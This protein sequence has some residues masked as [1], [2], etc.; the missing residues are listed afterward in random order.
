[1]QIFAPTA[2]GGTS[3]SIFVRNFDNLLI[4]LTVQDGGI[5]A[6]CGPASDSTGCAFFGDPFYSHS[7]RVDD[8]PGVWA[9]RV[10]SV[11]EPGTLLLMGLGLAGM[12]FSRKRKA[13]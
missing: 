10:T 9:Y 3:N 6:L 2:G 11:P 5:D 7:G 1:M 13:A 4:G 12:G 8:D